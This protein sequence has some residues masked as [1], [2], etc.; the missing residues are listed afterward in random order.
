MKF[1]YGRTGGVWV[2]DEPV[3][4]TPVTLPPRD[5]ARLEINKWS[6]NDIANAFSIPFAL[7]A[8]ASHNRQQLDAATF[9]HAKYGIVPRCNRNACVWNDLFVS[10]YDDSGRLFLAYD[11]PIPENRQEKMQENVQFV[12]N[13]I[14]TPNEARKEYGLPPLE[15]GDEL[16]PINVS[17]EMMRE[18]RAGSGDDDRESGD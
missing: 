17:P 1:T 16:R 9:M 7:I 12:M 18:N 4:A 5:L 14:K 11:D 6:K 10:L 8:D 2:P 15:G 3:T 13:G